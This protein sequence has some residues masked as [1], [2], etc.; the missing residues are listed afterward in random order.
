MDSLP[1]GVSLFDFGGDRTT[2]AASCTTMKEAIKFFWQSRLQSSQGQTNR[3][4]AD[5]GNRS[6]VTTGKNLDGF[7]EIIK[8][9]IIDNGI[10]GE[11]VIHKGKA[12]LTVPGFYRPT[13]NWDLL[14]MRDDQLLAAIEL[15]SQVGPSF[16]N[17]FNNRVEESLGNAMDM[18]A[19]YGAGMLGKIKPFIGYMFILEDCEKSRVAINSKCSNFFMSPEFD[20]TSYADRYTLLCRKLIQSG[21]YDAA[22]LILTPKR[23]VDTGEFSSL[24]E[25]TDTNRFITTLSLRMDMAAS[26]GNRA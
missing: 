10:P 19:A 17:N 23:A 5:Q 9:T 15:K 7:V 12:S 26:A 3:G 8:Q 20:K 21:L 14:V 11:C 6:H 2:N 13:K 16:G 25:V 22:S 4:T 18:R 1:T 24:S